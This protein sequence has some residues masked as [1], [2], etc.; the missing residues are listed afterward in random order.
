MENT[1]LNEDVRGSELWFPA[2][3]ELRIRGRQMAL[4]SLANV[5]LHHTASVRY[6]P[7]TENTVN[8]LVCGFT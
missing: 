7:P 5:P 8:S 2:L 1:A 6:E 3:I 4:Y